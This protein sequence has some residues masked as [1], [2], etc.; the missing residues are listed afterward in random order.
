MRRIA[1]ATLL[2]CTSVFAEVR[3]GVERPLTP[4][5]MGE[6]AVHR[7]PASIASD[8]KD[9][10]VLWYDGRGGSRNIVGAR[11]TADG[12]LLDP[13]G[14]AVTQFR[15]ATLAGLR[16]TGSE[17]LVTAD[18]YIPFSVQ[19]DRHYFTISREGEV[20]PATAQAAPETSWPVNDRGETVRFSGYG[21]GQHVLWFV[22]PNGGEAKAVD[23]PEHYAQATHV[24]AM[25][26]REF[27]VIFGSGR[28]AQWALFSRTQGLVRSRAM[29]SQA[30]GTDWVSE[31]IA[32][33]GSHVGAGWLAIT[34]VKQPDETLNAEYTSGWVTIDD[35]GDFSMGRFPDGS[36]PVQVLGDGATFHFISAASVT[37][38]AEIRSYRIFDG[39]V[40]GPF[41]V[42]PLADGSPSAATTGERNL[43]SW[44]DGCR[45]GPQCRMVYTTFARGGTPLEQEPVMLSASPARQL[46]PDAAYGDGSM[47][48]VWREAAVPAPIRGRLTTNTTARMIEVSPGGT[49]PRVAF[50]DGSYGVVWY[51]ADD[52]LLLLRRFDNAGNAIDANPVI[53]SRREDAREYEIVPRGNV[54]QVAWLGPAASIRTVA[55]PATGAVPQSVLVTG[56]TVD[57]KRQRMI[58]T[59]SGDAATIVWTESTKVRNEPVITW[60]ASRITGTNTIG[61]VIDLT[62]TA[63]D[64]AIGADAFAAA[65][66]DKA[67]LLLLP[68]SLKDGGCL[69]THT[70]SPDGTITLRLRETLT[71]SETGGLP[72]ASL[73]WDGTQWWATVQDRY[74]QSIATDG[75][76]GTAWEVADAATNPAIASVV[77]VPNGIAV[78]YLRNDFTYAGSRRAFV[79]VLGEQP[80]P[81]KGRAVR[82]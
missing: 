63:E 25:P 35:T 30:T 38:G 40:D 44:V 70:F 19:G 27:A 18:E 68:T 20:R 8:G 72:K 82:K 69:S 7:F 6:G 66:S 28:L 48:A 67:L 10:L 74:I 55:V 51:E 78:I 77:R 59:S 46:E 11:V 79:R 75:T 71:C 50:A 15:Q 56:G 54:L 60:R 43:L 58:L 49:L 22:D 34:Y 80:P 45:G 37:G 64:P 24:I 57:P 39:R 13:T 41:I 33:S 81:G 29:F 5:E 73:M 76:F 26:N 21:R 31:R 42:D 61:P 23:L 9:F 2:F 12:R 53:L 1:L 14:F 47:L 32:V 16:W 17:Y 36:N 52:E 3:L 65:L 4:L 62:R